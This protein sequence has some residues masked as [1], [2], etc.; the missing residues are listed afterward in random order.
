M[1]AQILEDVLYKAQDGQETWGQCG[2]RDNS[3]P[4]MEDVNNNISSPFCDFTSGIL[5]F[6]HIYAT[7]MHSALTLSIDAG[8]T[9]I[10]STS[11]EGHSCQGGGDPR[12]Q[13]IEPEIYKT[14]L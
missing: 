1:K 13:N 2:Y 3:S 5:S 14:L 8:T 4:L 6:C 11:T 7:F 12:G 9:Y 10:A